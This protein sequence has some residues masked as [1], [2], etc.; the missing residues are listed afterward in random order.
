[1]YILMM[2]E[3]QVKTAKEPGG[4]SLT[5]RRTSYVGVVLDSLLNRK[6]SNKSNPASGRADGE[7]QPGMK[8]ISRA[9]TLVGFQDPSGPP[10][11]L[12]YSVAQ[13]MV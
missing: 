13:R 3:L 1:M 4:S 5:K 6:L 9:G 8:R 10:K 11:H 2:G 7:F 12:R